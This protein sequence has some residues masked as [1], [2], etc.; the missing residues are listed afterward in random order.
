LFEPG[1]ARQQRPSYPDAKISQVYASLDYGENGRASNEFARLRD[2]ITDE[3]GLKDDST[4]RDAYRL[5]E[6][7]LDEP[8]RLS[9]Q[10]AFYV[11]ND[12][13]GIHDS[14]SNWNLEKTI[15]A[16]H[17]LL[18]DISRAPANR[19]AAKRRAHQHHRSKHVGPNQRAPRGDSAAKIVA[20]HG[21]DAAISERR[22]QP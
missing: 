2:Q 4:Y 7:T 19:H 12:S 11:Y 22:D 18:M 13:D 1:S 10:P 5:L 21:R 17:K 20:D 6:G 16:D 8:L 3:G 9:M 15:A 14:I